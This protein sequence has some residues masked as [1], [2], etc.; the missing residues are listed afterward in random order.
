MVILQVNL[1]KGL[2]V[3]IALMNLDTIELVAFEVER[4]GS[5]MPARSRGRTRPFLEQQA[6]PVLERVTLEA[7]ARLLGKMRAP[8]RVPW[9]S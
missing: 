3:V 7:E 5:C 1:D 8:S 2:P 9:L 6:L 4:T